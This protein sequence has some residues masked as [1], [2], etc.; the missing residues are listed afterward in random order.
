LTQRILTAIREPPYSDWAVYY[1]QLLFQH[2]GQPP[3]PARPVAAD[4]ARKDQQVLSVPPQL[5]WLWQQ[6]PAASAPRVSG[7]LTGTQVW[8]DTHLITPHHTQGSPN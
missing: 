6:E 1:I 3:R 4:R 8:A 5:G 7:R 2:P